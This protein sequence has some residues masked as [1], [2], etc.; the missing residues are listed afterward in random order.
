MDPVSGERLLRAR[1]REHVPGSWWL[2]WEGR[3]MEPCGLVWSGTVDQLAA[4][5]M[6]EGFTGVL[7][8]GAGA[9]A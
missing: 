7:V 3:G 5:A 6:A 8:Q 4:W 9:R 1:R 2:S